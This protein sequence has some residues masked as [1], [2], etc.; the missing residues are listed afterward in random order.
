MQ[1]YRLR[2]NPWLQSLIV[3][4]CV[5]LSNDAIDISQAHAEDPDAEL[6]ID[7][8]IE[9]MD[10][11]HRA[12]D[13][14]KRTYRVHFRQER[15]SLGDD[16][17]VRP[18]LDATIESEYARK[19]KFVFAHITQTVAAQ[20]API[21]EWVTWDDNI[22]KHRRSDGYSI[23]PDVLPQAHNYFTYTDALYADCYRLIEWKT[24]SRIRRMG[25]SPSTSN[26]F[27]LPRMISENKSKYRLHPKQGNVNGNWCHVLEW[28]HRDLIHVDTNHG[29]VV[30]WRKMWFRKD[31]PAGEIF[32]RDLYE[33]EPG[34]WLPKSQEEIRYY[35]LHSPASKL[36]KVMRNSK[37]KLLDISFA[38]LPDSFFEVPAEADEQLLVNDNIRK[39]QYWRHPEGSDP[40]ANAVADAQ[41]IARPRRS[42]E[43]WLLVNGIIV[44]VLTL[45][46]LVRT[47]KPRTTDA[48]P[49]F[50]D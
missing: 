44:G 18:E 36:G 29:F 38:P 33:H 40:V 49:K 23:F 11:L 4:S 10:T 1:L 43:P 19:G 7:E 17:E 42:R 26:V 50:V 9:G 30:R 32:N 8:I 21:E 41:M 16:G 24:P 15:E 31:V 6:T 22:C 28:P 13:P 27:L 34:L 14:A 3:V 35:N 37:T 2:R 45:L 39:I 47:S 5:T 46:W 48:S 20:Q 12:F 25:G